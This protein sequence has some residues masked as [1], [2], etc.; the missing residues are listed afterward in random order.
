[1]QDLLEFSQKYFSYLNN[2]LLGINL[3]AIKEEEEFYHK[4]ILDSVLPYYQSSLFSE[5]IES[6]GHVLDIGFG[7]GFPIL[8]LARILPQI[9]FL[10]VESKSKKVKAVGL[11]S[12]YFQLRNVSLV[13]SRF[14]EILIDKKVVVI[15]KAVSTV[16]NILDALVFD[17]DIECF[18]YKGPNFFDLEKT[19]L[20][21]ISSSWEIIENTEIEVPGT[22][23]RVLIGFKPKNVP[24]GTKK[25]RNLVK[26]SHI[27]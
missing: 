25:K 9:K 12:D 18:F 6:T 22:D 11:L 5:S 23:K 8:P 13:H 24:C 16:E 14:E 3:T 4:Q 10:G 27:L 17:A 7:G 26:L 2:E 21:K 15:S 19:G 1:M 20:E